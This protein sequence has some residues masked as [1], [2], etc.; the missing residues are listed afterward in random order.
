MTEI[1]QNITTELE[2]H[3]TKHRRQIEELLATIDAKDA[4]IGQVRR[5]ND[6]LKKAVNSIY[7]YLSHGIFVLE[8]SW[9]IWIFTNFQIFGIFSNFTQLFGIL[10]NYSEIFKLSRNN[11][12][13]QEK[14]LGSVKAKIAHC[15][16]ND[17]TFSQ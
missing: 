9:V 16:M 8:F 15:K 4:L 14:L 11:S 12:T 6:E 13:E 3:V 7:A 5:E 10:L 17:S 2:G 1:D